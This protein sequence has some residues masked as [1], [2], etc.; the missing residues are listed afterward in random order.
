MSI[1]A[2][3]V[4]AL[5]AGGILSDAMR[6]TRSRK[7][8]HFASHVPVTAHARRCALFRGLKKAL[9]GQIVKL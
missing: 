8:I 5:L 7:H 9:P 2:I 4:T 6:S 3:M 1:G